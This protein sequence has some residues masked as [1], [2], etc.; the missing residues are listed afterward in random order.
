MTTKAMLAV[1]VAWLGTTL[2]VLALHRPV[3][4]DVLWTQAILGQVCA[5]CWGL[6]A[7]M[8]RRGL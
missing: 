2:A 8:R 4:A 5:V 1:C 7:V 6:A 3:S